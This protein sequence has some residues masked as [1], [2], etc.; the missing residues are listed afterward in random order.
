MDLELADISRISFVTVA[1]GR[2]QAGHYTETKDTSCRFSWLK[3]VTPDVSRLTRA[4]IRPYLH[5]CK[6][7]GGTKGGTV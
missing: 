5:S 2:H 7:K 6:S 1:G 3:A 4:K